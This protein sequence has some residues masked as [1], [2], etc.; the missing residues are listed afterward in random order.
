MRY[1]SFACSFQQL[2][3]DRQNSLKR[4]TQHLFV[5]LQRW[6]ICSIFVV[7]Y[8]V[9]LLYALYEFMN[10]NLDY[11]LTKNMQKTTEKYFTNVFTWVLRDDWDVTIRPRILLNVAFVQLL[12]MLDTTLLLPQDWIS[13]SSSILDSPNPA[14]CWASSFWD[15]TLFRLLAANE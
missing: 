14:L 13:S 8:I 7:M 11:R 9:L 10:F 5:W 6:Y 3:A 1:E 15:K 4:K 12:A 2:I